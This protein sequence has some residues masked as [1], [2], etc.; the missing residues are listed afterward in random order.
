MMRIVMLFAVAI[1]SA[2]AATKTV[3]ALGAPAPEIVSAPGPAAPIA[4]IAT[5]DTAITKAADGHFWTTATVN[6]K[7]VRFL[8]DTG[9]TQVAL[10][11]EDAQRLGFVPAAADYTYK[12]ST[13]NGQTR[14]AP[15]KLAMVSVAGARVDNVEALVIENGL[16]NS[17]LGMTYLGRLSRFEASQTSLILRP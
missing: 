5:S 6:G 2:A 12:V 14:A 13:A 15:V 4:M 16:G 1:V 8:V 10:T 11:R 7:A 3:M 17:L 9:A